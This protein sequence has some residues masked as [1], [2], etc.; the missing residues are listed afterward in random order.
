MLVNRMG[1]SLQIRGPAATSHELQI[2]QKCLRTVALAE[3]P[4]TLSETHVREIKLEMV[5]VTRNQR[6]FTILTV[7]D[8]FASSASF[9]AQPK[10]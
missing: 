4:E 2:I 6:S 9:D 10:S 1:A 3:R 7:D 8:Q 5:S